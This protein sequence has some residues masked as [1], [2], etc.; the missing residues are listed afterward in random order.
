MSN[1]LIDKMKLMSDVNASLEKEIR[2]IQRQS[3]M[4]LQGASSAIIVADI[5]VR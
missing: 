2:Q 5:V 4:H 3:P 1:W